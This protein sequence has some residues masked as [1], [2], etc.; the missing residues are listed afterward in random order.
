MPRETPVTVDIPL[1]PVPFTLFTALDSKLLRA[2]SVQ[3]PGTRWWSSI[4][5][6]ATEPCSSLPIAVGIGQKWRPL[7][8]AICGHS[9]RNLLDSY[10]SGK[11]LNRDKTNILLMS[12]V[13]LSRQIKGSKQKGISMLALCEVRLQQECSTSLAGFALL[14]TFPP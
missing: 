7:S 1:R 11:C 6:C 9:G 4:P 12:V 13:Q 2:P 14:F 10:S 5:T 3:L 8:V